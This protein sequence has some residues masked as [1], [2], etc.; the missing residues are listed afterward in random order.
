MSGGY[1]H[2]L[3]MWGTPPLSCLQWWVRKT[4]A[5]GAERYLGG[6]QR[7]E[8][9]SFSQ[10]AI[11]EDAEGL[12]PLSHVFSA[13]LTSRARSFCSGTTDWNRPTLARHQNSHL[14]ALSHNR[15]PHKE[16]GAALKTN[17]EDVG[18]VSRGGGDEQPPRILRAGI[19]L[20]W[21]V[22]SHQEG[23]RARPSIGWVRQ[24]AR[25]H[26]ETNLMPINQSLR[27]QWKGSSPGFPHPAA[28]RPAPLVNKVFCFVSTCVSS[29]NSFP[30]VRQ[31]PCTGPEGVP[32]PATVLCWGWGHCPVSTRIRSSTSG[33]YLREA[34]RTASLPLWQPQIFPDMPTVS[35]GANSLGWEHCSSPK[36]ITPFIRLSIGG[37]QPQMHKRII[38]GSP[39][40]L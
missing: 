11:A 35:R 23:P 31:E 5:G 4:A 2:D 24:L 1:G 3:D 13:L 27:A 8:L 26:P 38:W 6:W 30:S 7:E 22:H 20:G 32:L 29:D 25:D 19:H 33:L 40:V 34:N 18:G 12:V 36:C 10:G 16:P 17:W 21:Q 14:H 15:R 37:F 28:L 39:E 9:P